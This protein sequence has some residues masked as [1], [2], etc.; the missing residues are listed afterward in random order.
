[1]IYLTRNTPWV[2]KIFLL[3]AEVYIVVMIIKTIFHI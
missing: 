2:I 3:I 1:M